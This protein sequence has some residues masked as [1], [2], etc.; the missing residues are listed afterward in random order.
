MGW[1]YRKSFKLLPGVKINVSSRGISTTIGGGALSV[2]VGPQGSF[3]NAG[4]PGTGLSL[5]ERLDGPP[6]DVVLPRSTERVAIESAST[7]ELASEALAQLQR[8]LA[9][10]GA[11]QRALDAELATVHPDAYAKSQRYSRW[12]RGFLFKHLMP[13]KFQRIAAE[14]QESAAHFAELQEQRKLAALA[15]TIEMA[16]EQKQ[17]FGRLCDAFARLSECRCIWDT[18]SIGRTD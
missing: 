6:P 12:H 16:E 5:R 13:G 17:P 11:E 10:A 7:Y 1:R 4:I 15:T 18:L 2:N 9:D 3:V 14:A 8:L